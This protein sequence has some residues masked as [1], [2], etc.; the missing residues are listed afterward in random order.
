MRLFNKD[1]FLCA[2]IDDTETILESIDTINVNMTDEDNESLLHYTVKFNCFEV[3]RILLSHNANVDIKNSNGDTPLM[4]ACKMGLDNF[5]KLF[6]RYNAN[7]DEKNSFGE[8]SLQMA[9]LNGNIDIIKF[10]INEKANIKTLT[11]S[12]RGIAHYAVKSG[13]LDV[14]KYIV[15]KCN[16]DVNCI[17]G[18]GNSLLHYA[19]NINNYEIVDFLIKRNACI[20]IR[21]IQYETPLFFAV[22]KS[23]ISII[24]YLIDLGAVIDIVNLFDESLLDVARED[25]RQYIESLKYNISFQDRYNKYP[26]HFAV[27]MD[28][29]DQV[30]FLLENGQKANKKDAYGKTAIDYAVES[31][32]TRIMRLFGIKK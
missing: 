9:I 4:L 8:T 21:N 23:S 17:D 19:V 5:I 15:D 3:A 18:A 24:D 27:L 6:L 12:N 29:A 14:L 30:S 28:D 26:L 10:L 7:I 2:K 16:C 1:F 22:Q 31:K 32:N 11:Y 25:V 13:K 20:H